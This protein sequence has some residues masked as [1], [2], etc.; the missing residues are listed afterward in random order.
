MPGCPVCPSLGFIWV[1]ALTGTF[2]SA[3]R[4]LTLSYCKM[5][6]LL[7]LCGRKMPSRFYSGK[8][9]LSKDAEFLSSPYMGYEAAKTACRNLKTVKKHSENNAPSLGASS[10]ANW[11][12]EV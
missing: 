7:V 6:R 12:I 5:L 9:F 3:G 8:A 1:L 11:C 4:L 10:S 2:P